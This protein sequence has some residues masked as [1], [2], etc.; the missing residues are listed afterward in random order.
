MDPSVG[1]IVHYVSHDT[2]PPSDGA[3]ATQP[4]CWPAMVTEVS[5]VGDKHIVGLAVYSPTG[6]FFWPLSEGGRHHQENERAVGSWHWPE[7]V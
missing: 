6:M 5:D 4:A 3:P 7:Q 1:R 2:P